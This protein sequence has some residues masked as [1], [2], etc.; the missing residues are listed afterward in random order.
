MNLRLHNFVPRSF[1]DEPTATTS[2]ERANRKERKEHIETRVEVD[3]SNSGNPEVDLNLRL[4]SF[5][6]LS[7][8]NGPGTR[9]VLWVQGC[10]LGCSGCFNP[11]TH[12]SDAGALISVEQLFENI[13]ALGDSIDG[14][15]ISG[16]EPLQ[17]LRTV[18]ELVH[19]IRTETL[20][21]IL[22][23]TGF[24]WEEVLRKLKFESHGKTNLL[25]EIDAIICGRFDESLRIARG[26]RGSANKSIRLLTDRYRLEDFHTQ[27]EAEVVLESDGELILSGIDPLR[28]NE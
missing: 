7:Y 23:F 28:W 14:V 3:K 13:L 26:L 9:A 1:V 10:S 22:V 20:L 27:P 21:S 11:E 24:R 19:R 18:S 8:A 2:T 5:A 16:G 15:T 17:Q 25:N 12:S 6:P 4:H